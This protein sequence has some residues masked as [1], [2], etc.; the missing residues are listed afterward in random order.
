MDTFP[1]G[2]ISKS[3]LALFNEIG[4]KYEIDFLLMKQEGLFIPLIPKTV[5]LLNEPISAEFRNPNPK[6]I[7]RFLKTMSFRN[8]LKWC[9]YSFK[10]SIGKVTKGLHGQVQAMDVWLGKHTQPLST[11]QYDAAIAYQGGRCIYYLVENV[12]AK[13]KIGYV[14]SDYISNETDF[15]LFGSDKEYF[16]KLDYLVTI[17]E[18]CADSLKK[19]FPVLKSKV[20]V[21]EN[22]CSPKMI[23]SMS[24]E[25]KPFDDDFEGFR[26]LTMGRL[27]WSVKGLDFILEAAALLRKSGLVFKW[28]LLGDGH[29]RKKVEQ[30]IAD[31][32]LQGCVEILGAKTNPYPYIAACDIYVHPSRVEGKSVALD[33]VK[34]LAKPVVVT[35]FS[36]VYDQFDDGK[37][38]LIC[39]MDS[40]DI[41]SK[42]KKLTDSPELRAELSN[43]LKSEK[44]GNTEQAQIFESLLGK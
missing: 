35:N 17:S 29:S 3:L 36:T 4:D 28:Y 11:K 43:N 32:S 31:K 6:N 34:A 20:K 26:L 19:V 42:I 21:V 13:V 23:N 38:A 24:K 27:D 9:S 16:P 41:A 15:M 40:M 33:E 18:K 39:Q 37:T 10:C 25:F 8:W 5:D 7:V 2:G 12:D 14:H 22:I 1:L 30:G 44:V